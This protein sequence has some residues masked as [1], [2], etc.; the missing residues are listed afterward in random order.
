MCI[1]DRIPKSS[2]TKKAFYLVPEDYLTQGG[3]NKEI[4]I[5]I[6]TGKDHADFQ[7]VDVDVYKRQG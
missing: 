2:V 7:N 5:L 6:D 1:R 3:N 4:G